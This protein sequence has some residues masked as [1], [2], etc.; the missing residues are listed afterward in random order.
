MELTYIPLLAVLVSLAA[1]PFILMSSRKPN[2]REFWTILAGV[3]KFLL[4]VS[5]LPSA[6]QGE[7]VEITLA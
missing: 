7:A 5:L 6:L 4:V 1:V 3:I 2:L